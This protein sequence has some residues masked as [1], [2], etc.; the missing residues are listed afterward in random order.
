MTARTA[1]VAPTPLRRNRAFSLLW[2]G[3]GVSVLGSMTGT[4]VLP[5]LAIEHFNATPSRWAC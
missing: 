4:V 5:L 3:E 1:P 2:F